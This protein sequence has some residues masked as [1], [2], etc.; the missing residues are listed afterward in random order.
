M[1]I[2]KTF[3]RTFFYATSLSV[4][5]SN[6]STA[7]DA[8]HEKTLSSGTIALPVRVHRFTSEE[9][10]RL[11]CSL[12]DDEIRQQFEVVNETWVQAGIVWEIESIIDV[13][14]RRPK[15]FT[16]AMDNPRGTLAKALASN[17]PRKQLLKD[18]FNVV[19]A[20]DYGSSIGGVF[21]PNEDGL[22]FFAKNGPKGIQT[23]AVLAHELGHSLGLP[24]TIFEKDNNLMMGSAGGRVPTLT[25]P[26]TP[27][28]IMIARL[29]ATNGKPFNPPRVK[30]PSSSP[31]K[32]FGILDTNK[33]D[34]LT[35]SEVK[36]THRAYT[37]DFF[38]K[39]SR[40]PADSLSREEYD[41]I[42]AQQEQLRQRSQQRRQ[43]QQGQQTNQ[44]AYGPEIA[45]Q[46][47]SR[48]DADKDDQITRM[49]ASRPGSL[50]NE[51]FDKWDSETNGDGILSR[52]EIIARL[53]DEPAALG[54]L[55]K[56]RK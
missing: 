10:A 22:V 12:S 11:H 49:E 5:I 54:A 38:R 28:Q 21:L 53:S 20:E 16:K 24:H 36:E 25:K 2:M 44:R 8:Q 3:G 15:D 48:F 9:E 19:I 14:A 26:I 56:S 51:Y 34:V 17:M 13:V 27:S 33:D 31:V 43:P 37:I 6:L 50:I 35:V 23:P 4:L 29:Y 30:A 55:K 42:I 7:L 1:D 39:A 18:G 52:D 41:F 40:S 46:I 47:F 45:P 32:I